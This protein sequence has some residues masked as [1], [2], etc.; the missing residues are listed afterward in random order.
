[1]EWHLDSGSHVITTDAF[2]SISTS[3]LRMEGQNRTPCSRERGNYV[4]QRLNNFLLAL[5][6]VKIPAFRVSSSLVTCRPRRKL[7]LEGLWVQRGRL[8]KD[9]LQSR[10]AWGPRPHYLAIIYEAVT[11]HETSLCFLNCEMKTDLV[12][13][14]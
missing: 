4:L 9:R 6:I 13:C 12:V 2:I 3:S 1:M 8:E 14:G 10:L 11:N 7:F 5:I